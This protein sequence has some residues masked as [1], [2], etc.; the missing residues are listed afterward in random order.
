M[1]QN[2]KIDDPWLD[3][4][5]PQSVGASAGAPTGLQIATIENVEPLDA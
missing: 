2:P 5:A 3:V 4:A 1:T